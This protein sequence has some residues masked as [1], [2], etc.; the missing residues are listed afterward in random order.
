MSSRAF[1]K[2][3]VIMGGPSA[4]REV[5]LSSGRECATALRDAG[6]SEV[7]MLDAGADLASVWRQ[8]VLTLFSMHCM[9][10]GAK[11]VVFRASSNG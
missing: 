4:E 5:S 7:V 9:V 6:Y 1:P 11:T 8:I 3:T 2:V 10:V